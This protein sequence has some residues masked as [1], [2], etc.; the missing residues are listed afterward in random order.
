M[1]SEHAIQSE[2]RE[3]SVQSIRSSGS[4]GSLHTLDSMKSVE[5]VHAEKVRTAADDEKSP[6][7]SQSTTSTAG[8]VSE[9]LKSGKVPPVVTV[10]DAVHE[11]TEKVPASMS[12]AD[13]LE[14]K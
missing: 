4:M 13:A 8:P 10:V 7:L 14:T 5:S 1:H 3:D 11:S 9:P 6:K 12:G 2:E